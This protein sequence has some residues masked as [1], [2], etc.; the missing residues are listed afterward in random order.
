MIPAVVFSAIVGAVVYGR[1]EF[2]SWGG[3]MVV[4]L[5][6][7]LSVCGV[8]VNVNYYTDVLGGSLAYPVLNNWDSSIDW[9]RA[10]AYLSGANGEG[11]H[12]RYYSAVI[13]ALIAVFGQDISVPLMFNSLCY[14]LLLI[15]MGAV[16]WQLS[17]SR[18]MATATMA[19]ALCMCYLFVQSTVLLKDVPLT[20]IVAL[21]V[22]IFIKWN[23]SYWWKTPAWQYAAMLL[24]MVALQFLRVN[25]S[26][27]LMVGA[28]IFALK[29]RP[30]SIDPRFVG[31]ILVAGV[32]RWLF[33]LWFTEPASV[34]EAVTVDSSESIQ[35]Y[36]SNS[37][38]WD[39]M[40]GRYDSISALRRLAWLP[41]SVG[42]QFIIPFPWTYMNYVDF[43][44]IEPLAH[45]GFT[46][47][48]AG[49][50]IVYWIFADARR[51][52]YAMPRL[53]AWGAIATVATAYVTA[54]HASRYCLV[55]LPML[56]PAAAWV[57]CHDM[58]R[59]SLW[60]WLAIFAVLLTAALAVGY[61][62]QNSTL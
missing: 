53:V 30:L 44:P 51:C 27:I 40:T 36:Q 5:G 55:Y 48:L 26:P 42:V 49:A 28:L 46:W 50:M 7:A 21:I 56:L 2:R 17:G 10:L 20:L 38:A 41:V 31:V 60:I 11:M 35:M 62:L 61:H 3:A 39:Q 33:G 52:D 37:L 23:K 16:A 24:L 6:F 19:V 57:V 9:Q 15:T 47:Y 18:K 43:S 59:R 14:T 54:G 1:C 25:F 58:R 34:L 12:T 22:L 8:I 29:F 13:A 45:F 4:A 32:L